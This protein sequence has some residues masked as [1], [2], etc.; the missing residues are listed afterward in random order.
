[1]AGRVPVRRTRCLLAGLVFGLLA[2]VM[3]AEAAKETTY[4]VI[5]ATNGNVLAQ[6]KP[7]K[8]MYPASLAKMMTLYLVF[9]ALEKGT[10]T[11][12]T[13]FTFS[14]KASDQVPSKLGIPRGGSISAQDAIMALVIKS[15]ND[16]AVAVAE[17]LGG[18]EAGFT[19][20]MTNKARELGMRRTVFTNA[21]GLHRRS[22]TSTARDMAV[23][24]LRLQFDFPEYYPLFSS[25]SFTYGDRT[26]RSHN[27]LLGRVDGVDGIKTGYT[28][29]AGWNLAASAVVDGRRIVGVVI[30]G[31]DRIS[32]DRLMTD[33]IRKAFVTAASVDRTVPLPTSHPRRD[34]AAQFTAALTSGVDDELVASL[35]QSLG[36]GSSGFA[37][38]EG[39]AGDDR[40]WAI[41]VGAFSQRDNAVRASADTGRFLAPLLAGD[42]E[43]VLATVEMDG[44]TLYRVRILNLG[45]VQARESCRFLNSNDRPCSVIYTGDS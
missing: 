27:K 26:Y 32:R 40:N 19:T 36:L 28:K 20:M 9:E 37:V 30:G 14:R 43:T 2:G 16:V 44:A 31:K 1:M 45:E 34:V 29:A 4:F 38:D 6:R 10:I 41:Q 11:L 12:D 7:D 21:S 13:R 23:L 33:L 39:S 8:E 25:R 22:M 42:S 3:D 35:E 17:G 15:A 5:D 24:A 18:S